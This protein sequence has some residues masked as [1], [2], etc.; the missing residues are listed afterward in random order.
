MTTI[1]TIALLS[2]VCPQAS[3]EGASWPQ[4]MGP[5]R[6]GAT[7]L[8]AGVTFEWGEEGPEE[9]WRIEV[10]PG[11]GGVSVHDGEVFLLDRAPMEVD[12]LR[13]FDLASGEELWSWIHEQDGRLNFPGSRTVPTV[14]EEEIFICTGFGLVAGFDRGDRDVAWQVRLDE[15]YGG[16]LPGYGWSCSPVLVGDNVVVSALGEEVGLVAFDRKT[17]EEAWVTKPFGTSHSTPVLLT[18]LGQPQ[19]VFVHAP[20][21]A[22]S[23]DAA[24]TLVISSFDPDDGSLLWETETEGTSYPIPGPV[25]VDEERF[26]VTGGYRGGTS[27]LRIQRA[28]E[29]GYAF[30][31]LFRIARGA[32]IHNPILHDEHLYLLVN[33]NWNDP[34]NRRAEGGLLCLGLDGKER[35]RTGAD[36]YFGRGNALLA[37]DHLLVQDGYDGVLRVVAA[38]PDGYEAVAEA[39]VFGI[40]DRADHQMWAPMALAGRH[41]LLRSQEELV[42]LRL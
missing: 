2:L 28:A 27:L 29:G 17:G 38:K 39:N 9:V 37:G 40:D 8:P 23:L 34:R 25:Q 30:E 5:E 12:I 10:G 42:C 6:T 7:T 20:P 15:D 3:D 1:P 14:T 24:G 13:V 19:L 4:Y 31:R 36:P 26:L 33:E 32:Q 11:Y 16:I 22:G 35:W 21:G 41:L 18:L